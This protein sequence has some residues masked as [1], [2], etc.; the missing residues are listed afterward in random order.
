[1][2]PTVQCYPDAA[3]VV[4]AGAEIATREISRAVAIRGRAWIVLAGGETPRAL[5][6]HLAA[7]PEELP[8][9]RIWWC[10][11]DERWVARTD[12][13]NNF[14]MVERVLFSQAP[15]PRDHILAVPTDEG[16]ARAGA[17]AY[18]A[19]LRTQFPGAAWPE[20]D[21]AVMGLGADGH[22]ASLFP[23]D[24]ALNER[25]AWVTTTRAGKP[26]ADRVTL[27]APAFAH[28]R[29]M[30]F[31]VT[32]AAKAHAVTATLDAPNM[33][34]WPAQAVM[35][36]SGRCY[37]LLDHDAASALPTGWPPAA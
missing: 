24:S 17:R 33:T 36:R 4:A 15:I 14:A 19:A 30:T 11:G 18:E 35:P 26:V 9:Q 21:V 28:T 10:F 25:S 32:G 6:A 16:D 34:Q 5:Y 7:S 29:V 23:D 12:P 27:T 20:F 31:L 22:T 13:L 3:H 37:W 1:V 2:S 8:W